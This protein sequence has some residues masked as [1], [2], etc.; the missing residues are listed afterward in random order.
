MNRKQILVVVADKLTMQ[1]RKG[2]IK[3]LAFSCLIDFEATHV[4]LDRL[5][6]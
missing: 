2:E 6:K 3:E 5:K 1:Q 4:M